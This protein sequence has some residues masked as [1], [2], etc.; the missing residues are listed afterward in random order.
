MFPKLNEIIAVLE[1]LAPPHLAEEW[2]NSG[3]MVGKKNAEVRKILLALDATDVVLKEAVEIGAN[4]VITH[5]PMV[6]APLK[7]VNDDDWVGKKLIYAIENGVSVYAAHTNLD[8]AQGG[9]NDAFAQML[10]LTDIKPLDE[11]GR[12]RVGLLPQNIAI[13]KLAELAKKRLE[14]DAVRCV[15]DVSR[16]AQKVAICTGS[17][18]SMF[19]DAIKSKADVFITADVKY[20]EALIAQESG[21]P[22]ID[23]THYASEN[24]VFASLKTYLDAEFKGRGID[25]V[26]SKIDGQ[27]FV[28]I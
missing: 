3:L 24:L 19:G 12:G 25:V 22:I 8:T 13:E 18:M 7:S 14:L 6:F 28:N 21:L 20:H 2:D 27:P 23:A 15:G 17:G 5:H 16:V 26:I 4:L 10:G 1:R 9:T 11:F